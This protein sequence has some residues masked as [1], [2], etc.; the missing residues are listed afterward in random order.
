MT[1]SFLQN[2]SPAFPKCRTF[3][4]PVPTQNDICNVVIN[5]RN[6]FIQESTIEKTKDKPRCVLELQAFITLKAYMNDLRNAPQSL[7]RPPSLS[8]S[9][10]PGTSFCL[11]S[12]RERL[13]GWQP[14]QGSSVGILPQLHRNS[15]LHCFVYNP[16]SGRPRSI[17]S[18]PS[19]RQQRPNARGRWSP[20]QHLE[21]G[22]QLREVDV[23]MC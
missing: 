20:C 7:C 8:S 11:A 9:H 17:S 10:R 2:T 23:S 5:A 19:R 21:A 12:L 1:N 18:P 6:N 3:Q 22:Y 14:L 4:T 16:H 15:A 13:L